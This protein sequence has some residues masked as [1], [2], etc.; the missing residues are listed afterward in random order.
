MNK[1]K[2]LEDMDMMELVSKRQC[3]DELIKKKRVQNEIISLKEKIIILESGKE[4]FECHN[5]DGIFP[6]G[7]HDV[8]ECNYINR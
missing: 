6:S 5:C 3:I 8:E 4:V 7:E 1:E 2:K